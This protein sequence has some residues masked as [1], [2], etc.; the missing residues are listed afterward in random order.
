MRPKGK[1]VLPH[2]LSH[3]RLP[4]A[5][6][7]PCSSVPVSSRTTSRFRGLSGAR[8][9]CLGRLD[10]HLRRRRS[11]DSLHGPSHGFLHS[12]RRSCGAHHRGPS[13]DGSHRSLSQRTTAREVPQPRQMAT[14]PGSGCTS[15]LTLLPAPSARRRALER[16]KHPFPV[17]SR[18][19]SRGRREGV[20]VQSCWMFPQ[21]FS[22]VHLEGEQAKGSS[23]YF[24]HSQHVRK[25]VL[26]CY[27]VVNSGVCVQVG[28][29]Y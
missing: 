26:F 7:L 21:S 4:P 5:S 22:H 25:W 29:G 16:H 14:G 24:S 3:L 8:D 11:P 15:T 28:P 12:P 20:E 18:V 6:P 10:H 17:A 2:A 1:P 23:V 9:V 19:D 13:S 27:L